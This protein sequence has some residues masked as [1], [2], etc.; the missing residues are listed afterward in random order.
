MT[1]PPA[2]FDAVI[3]RIRALK[4]VGSG[5]TS[6][7]QSSGLRPLSERPSRVYRPLRGLSPQLDPISEDLLTDLEITSEDQNFLGVISLGLENDA[8]ITP[9]YAR[10]SKDFVLSAQSMRLLPTDVS[11]IV[12]EEWIVSK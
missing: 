10:T 6:A 5:L 2:D 3:T 7:I 1:N 12:G 8:P 11:T 9:R 4:S